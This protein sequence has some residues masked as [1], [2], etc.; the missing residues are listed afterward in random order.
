MNKTSISGIQSR[1]ANRNGLWAVA[2]A[3]L[4]AAFFFN[5]CSD[6][7][8][9]TPTAGSGGG[10]MNSGGSGGSAPA[11]GG[12][13]GSS[14]TGAGSGGMNMGGT[15]GTSMTTGPTGTIE[16]LTADASL[17]A[18][19]TTVAIRGDVV[20][21]PLANFA[22]IGATGDPSSVVSVPLAGGAL[23]ASIA[24]PDDFHPEGITIADDG[25]LYIGS[26]TTGGI[27]R[28]PPNSTTAEEFVAGGAVAERGVV[29]LTVDNDRDLVWFCDSSPVAETPGGAIVGVSTAAATDGDEVVRHALPD[30]AGAE[31]DAGVA[32]PAFCNDLI[33]T[34]DG[35]ILASESWTGRIYRVASASVMTANSAAVW[36]AAPELEPADPVNGFGVN[37]LELVGDQLVFANAGLFVMDPDSPDSAE[38]IALSG[39]EPLFL[40]GPDGLALV[41]DSTTELVVADNGGRIIKVTLD[42]D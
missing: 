6:D 42:L 17:S 9:D 4:T 26:L 15:A 39:A 18:N 25:T 29:G 32:R 19:P 12:A 1:L 24:L 30:G 11:D 21:A 38:A 10:G 14:M 23:G 20:F 27:Q 37:G 35:D 28:V 2:G 5:A 41:P 31:G 7:D 8:S 33:V 22:Q 36:S 40:G 13:S 34:P 16:V 3:A